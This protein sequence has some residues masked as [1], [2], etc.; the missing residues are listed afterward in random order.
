MTEL[1]WTPALLL[2]AED[3]AHRIG[4]IKEVRVEYL[5][6]NHTLDDVLWPLIQRKLQVV[7]AALDGRPQQLLF[8]D[9][10]G[11]SKW[12]VANEARFLAHA[13]TSPADPR[14]KNARH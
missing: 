5:V 1:H 12:Q 9:L 11:D 8:N 6:A 14:S 3:R 13:R 4:Q 10:S 2:Q 7:G